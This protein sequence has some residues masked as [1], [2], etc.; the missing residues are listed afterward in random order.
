MSSPAD[1]RS[2]V[3]GAGKLSNMDHV[4]V[5]CRVRPLNSKEL[6]AGGAMAL[7]VEGNGTVR[8]GAGRRAAGAG[9]VSG[10]HV[11]HPVARVAIPGRRSRC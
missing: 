3:A 4:R 11:T 7:R 2:G 10:L 5:F 8:R 9:C 6:A 1:S